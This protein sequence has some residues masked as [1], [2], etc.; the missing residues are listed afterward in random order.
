MKMK[1]DDG[2]F[3]NSLAVKLRSLVVPSFNLQNVSGFGITFPSSLF[4]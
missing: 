3:Q 2:K 4:I 1:N